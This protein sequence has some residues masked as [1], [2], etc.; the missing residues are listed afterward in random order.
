MKKLLFFLFFAVLFYPAFPEKILNAENMKKDEFYPV[1]AF[2]VN[3]KNNDDLRKIFDDLEKHNVNTIIFGLTEEEMSDTQRFQTLASL[4]DKY[5]IKL[6][7]EIH[8]IS[9]TID[10]V[11]KNPEMGLR[12]LSGEFSTVM[13]PSGYRKGSYYPTLFHPEVRKIAGA[14]LT[15]T[16][17]LFQGHSSFLAVNLD[18]EPGLS[19]IG[20]KV[21]FQG[22]YSKTSV[23]EFKKETGLD[24]PRLTS[25]EVKK[26]YPPGLIISDQDPW[27]KWNLFRLETFRNFYQYL[28]D[29]GNKID[30]DVPLTTQ[31]NAG[32]VAAY[33]MY[34]RE[35]YAPFGV[36]NFHAYPYREPQ[37][38]TSY[39]YDLA[40]TASWSKKPLWL[41][42]Q[43]FDPWGTV[44]TPAM[45]RLQVWQG[46]AGGARGIGFFLYNALAESGDKWIIY[47]APETWTD[48]GRIFQNIKVLAPRLNA[49]KRSSRQIALLQSVTTEIVQ[50]Y[51]I[52]SA[53][54][55]WRQW[56]SNEQAYSALDRTH[57]P[58]EMITEDDVLEGKINNYKALILVNVENLRQSAAAAIENYIKQGGLVYA[59]DTT[60]V[61]LKGVN[62]LG[63]PVNQ[64][65]EDFRKKPGPTA[66]DRRIY[67]PIIDKQAVEFEK[68]FAHIIPYVSCDS[69]DIILRTLEGKEGK[70]LFVI[71]NS[72][73]WPYGE[74][75]ETGRTIT[76]RV[77]IT[78]KV[79]VTD[80]ISGKKPAD[81]KNAGT[82]TFFSV[83]VL[84]GD[85][86]VFLLQ[87]R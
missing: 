83:S 64:M 60:R 46:I 48:A 72:L 1:M 5:G 71:N 87:K 63:F 51:W 85:A 37:T 80:V 10:K 11:E 23:M 39:A 40:Q 31:V 7:P 58:F 81:L 41:T 57:I 53:I 76:T 49:M 68:I 38:F 78:D 25:E 9:H 13:F 62:K 66:R 36:V 75:K 35:T 86:A 6:M 59:D 17:K 82:E 16:L 19:F 34:W 69:R 30:P 65:Y 20:E 43:A 27:L 8:A 56:H 4:A 32:V 52:E 74:Q 24:P 12:T 70:L 3:W 45:L 77:K 47:N 79:G 15:N 54:E 50:G 61:N 42:V 84:P 55:C 33:G 26:R 73:L 67:Y 29:R 18:D 14:H 2:A 28:E 21:D 22:D 44:V